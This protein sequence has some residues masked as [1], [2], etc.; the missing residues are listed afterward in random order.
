M[1][2]YLS[3]GYLKEKKTRQ[4]WAESKKPNSPKQCHGYYRPSILRSE[5]P[6]GG[7]SAEDDLCG[8]RII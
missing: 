4:T 7:A 6:K 5:S 1:V 8:K 3:Q 2:Y